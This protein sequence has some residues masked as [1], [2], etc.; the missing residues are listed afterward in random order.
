ML[1]QRM[2]MQR[3][4]QDTYTWT[5]MLRQQPNAPANHCA[6]GAGPGPHTTQRSPA[7]TLERLPSE[8]S[9]L[10]LHCIPI[11]DRCAPTRA[12]SARSAD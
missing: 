12:L 7:E 2:L 6:G 10:V 1:Q 9:E 11:E 8:L 5:S 4:M 3:I